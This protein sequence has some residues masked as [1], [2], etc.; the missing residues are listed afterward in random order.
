MNPIGTENAREQRLN[1]IRE[2]AEAKGMVQVPGVRPAGSP[3]P[4]A[5]PETGYYGQ[6]LLKGPQWTPLVPVYFF[7]GGASGALGVIGSLADLL[8]RDQELARKARWMALAGTGLSS[9]LLI[10]DL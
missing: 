7:V 9:A 4:M 2:E 3:I 8:G 1:A 5:S 10:A 6:P